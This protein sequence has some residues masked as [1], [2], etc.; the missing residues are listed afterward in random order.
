[1]FLCPLSV[2][3]SFLFC[4]VLFCFCFC[5]CFLFFFQFCVLTYWDHYHKVLTHLNLSKSTNQVTV[6]NE[7]MNHPLPSVTGVYFPLCISYWPKEGRAC[8]IYHQLWHLRYEILQNKKFDVEKV[9]SKLSEDFTTVIDSTHSN[10]LFEGI[11]LRL[12]YDPPRSRFI[13]WHS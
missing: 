3:L 13:L 12:W 5:F 10:A 4:F 6:S 1:M 2:F 8:L 7:H 11:S 9:I